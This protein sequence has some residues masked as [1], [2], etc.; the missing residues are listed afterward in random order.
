M[1]YEKYKSQLPY[2]YSLG[3]TLTIELLKRHPE[4][5]L[6]IYYHSSFNGE[7]KDLIDTLAKKI[8]IT[9]T[10]NDKIFN[11]V[12]QKENVYC[13]GVFKKFSSPIKKDEN[14]IVLVN[15]SNAGN[16]GTIIRTSAGFNLNNLVIIKPAVD[17]FDPKTVRASMGALFN[18]NFSLYD[19]FDDYKKDNKH[20]LYPFM[21]KAKAKLKDTSFSKPYSLIFGNEAT[22]LPDSFLEY[23]S[24]I[25]PH[26]HA[27]DSLNLPI[28]VSIALYCATSSD[29]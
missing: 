25:I 2:S 12:S 11:I 15:P 16:L 1:K 8:N 27:I 7:G 4:S 29:F 14:H 9:P 23:N 19:N 24:V 26:S 21:L 13:I 5:V 6:D 22:G 3:I 17:I 20:N 10:L 18:I 28:A